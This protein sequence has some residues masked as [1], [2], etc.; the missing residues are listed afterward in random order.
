MNDEHDAARCHALLFVDGARVLFHVM[1]KARP[2]RPVSVE[3]RPV[4]VCV[5]VVLQALLQDTDDPNAVMQLSQVQY[6][7]GVRI[8]ISI[9][10]TTITIRTY[11]R[12]MASLSGYNVSR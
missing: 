5:R 1:L 3:A 4:C 8:P 12:D 11:I 6:A 2:H 7:T 9:T 10:L